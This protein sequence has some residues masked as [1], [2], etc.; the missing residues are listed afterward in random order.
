V[1]STGSPESFE[2]RDPEVLP[3]IERWSPTERHDLVRVVRA[4]GGRL[5]S[6]DLERI[7]RIDPLERVLLQSGSEPRRIA[8]A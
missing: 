4:R 1:V 8:M 5:E 7:D 6:R 2:A 3:G